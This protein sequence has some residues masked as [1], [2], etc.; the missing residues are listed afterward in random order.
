M[1]RGEKGEGVEESSSEKRGGGEEGEGGEGGRTAV[2]G[3]E[4]VEKAK[5][6]WRKAEQK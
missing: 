3:R 1:G 6:E 5:I 2:V 4:E